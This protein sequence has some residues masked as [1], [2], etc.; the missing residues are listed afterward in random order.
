MNILILHSQVPYFRG[1]AELLVD[2]LRCAL[3]E[4]GHRTDV[5]SIPLTWNP[6]E[7]L[8][9][10]A[11]IWRMTDVTQSNGIPVDM[12]ICTKYPTWAARHP[13]KVLWLVHQHRQAYDLFGSPHSELGGDQCSNSIRRRVVDIDRRGMLECER[14]FAISANVASRLSRYTGVE[15][16]PLYPP[17]PRSGL[18]PEAYEP[19][20]LSAARLDGLKRVD[21]LIDAWRH[22]DPSLRLVIASDGPDREELVRRIRS[23]DLSDRVMFT[24]RISD[25]ELT[26]L[27]NRC[28]AVYYA[29][30]D[31]DYGYS[32]VEAMSAA[33]PVITAPDSGGVLEF[34]E[35]GRSGLVTELTPEGLST[36]INQLANETSARELGSKGAASLPDLSWD[37]VVSN[38]L[39]SGAP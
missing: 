36:V 39:G 16:D 29:P 30:L 8:L 33:K 20:V 34:V 32:A 31:E 10:N 38:L 1:G 9:S 28:R 25:E 3:E 17:V 2:G 15:A 21:K 18:K 4:R 24:G 26:D 5:V 12:V 37:R 19:F 23:S 13:R 7:M 14:R 27:Y 6:P 22:V 35:H 11:L